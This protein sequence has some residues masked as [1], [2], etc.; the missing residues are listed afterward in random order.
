M[1]RKLTDDSDIVCR[2]TSQAKHPTV[3]RHWSLTGFNVKL[4]WARDCWVFQF[5]N[6]TRSGA[7]RRARNR[8]CQSLRGVITH[9]VPRPQ[10]WCSLVHALKTFNRPLGLRLTAVKNALSE[11]LH[12]KDGVVRASARW[13]CSNARQSLPRRLY[14]GHPAR[15]WRLPDIQSPPARQ[16]R[17]VRPLSLYGRIGH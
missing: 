6:G 12:L 4:L 8:N 9:F 16:L 1:G 2:W 7:K 14:D 17:W 11:V 13:S 5:L 15:R 3:A 10:T